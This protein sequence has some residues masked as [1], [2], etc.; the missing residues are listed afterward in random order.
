[1]S[2][3]R[4]RSRRVGRHMFWSAESGDAL[5]TRSRTILGR[6]YTPDSKSL[7]AT[8]P[9]SRKNVFRPD[10][11]S[12]NMARTADSYRGCSR[13]FHFGFS[14]PPPWYY[15]FFHLVKSGLSTLS[16]FN[17][18]TSLRPPVNRSALGSSP[19]FRRLFSGSVAAGTSHNTATSKQEELQTNNQRSGRPQRRTNAQ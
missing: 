11:Q 18:S 8:Q 9:L 3:H 17:S 6:A 16:V 1:M 12:A 7:R 15:R 10:F 5:S 2:V 14:V 19:A 13:P 4:I